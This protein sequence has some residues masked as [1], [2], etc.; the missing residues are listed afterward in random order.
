MDEEARAVWMMRVPPL[1]PPPPSSLPTSHSLVNY[2]CREKESVLV[3]LKNTVPED[4]P[5]SIPRKSECTI[6]W[7]S[8]L[9]NGYIYTGM[10]LSE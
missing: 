9:P 2:A 6:K 1:P 7:I 5:E 8:I 4:H 10:G 3:V